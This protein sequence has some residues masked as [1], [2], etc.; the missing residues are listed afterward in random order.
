MATSLVPVLSEANPHQLAA[1]ALV[2]WVHALGIIV[3]I[4]LA[5]A[6]IPNPLVL[7]NLFSTPSNPSP[8]VP[9]LAFSAPRR[10][11]TDVPA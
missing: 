11:S 3:V 8:M 5:A 6:A 1:P 4:N 9:A 7:A 2:L 10:D